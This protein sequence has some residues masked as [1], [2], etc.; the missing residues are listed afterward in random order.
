MVTG[1]KGKVNFF[2]VSF[3][4]SYPW[5]F[6]ISALLHALAVLDYSPKLSGVMGLA[7]SADFLH[8]FFHKNVSY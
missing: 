8:T 3:K 5:T 7:V 1:C 2:I 4:T 6:K